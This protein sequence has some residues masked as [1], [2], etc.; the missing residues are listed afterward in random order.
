MLIIVLFSLAFGAIAVVSMWRLF[1][2]AGREGWIALVPICNTLTVLR[3]AGR[4]DWWLALLFIPC[5]NVFFIFTV[6]A[7]LARS[8]GRSSAFG[9]FGLGFIGFR[10]LAFGNATYRGPAALHKYQGGYPPQH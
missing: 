1:T 4:P 8:S 2:K 3:M 9:I 5:A 7:D 6:M 10:V